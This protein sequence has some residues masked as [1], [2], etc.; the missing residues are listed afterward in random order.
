MDEIQ[1]K[2]Q[3]QR[4]LIKA[5]ILSSFT[6]QSYDEIEKAPSNISTGKIHKYVGIH[7]S[8]NGKRVY[9]YED[10]PDIKRIEGDFS[11]PSKKENEKHMEVTV[12][13]EGRS[14]KQYSTEE[15]ENTKSLLQK[16][17]NLDADKI[18]I[19]PSVS[20]SSLYL[21][22]RYN[23]RRFDIR[24]ADHTYKY[25]KEEDKILLNCLYK[26]K[27]YIIEAA[28]YNYSP[29]DIVNAVKS[30]NKSLNHFQSEKCQESIKE[31][32]QENYEKVGNDD[33]YDDYVLYPHNTAMDLAGLYITKHKI[34]DDEFNSKFHSIRSII[35]NELEKLDDDI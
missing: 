30:L 13:K 21:K 9:E 26:N 5:N 16:E 25:P 33:D 31:F 19:R 4:L 7:L 28:V 2:I 34:I 1:Y 29:D 17:L 12:D 15:I 27:K 20:T 23:N 22:F 18:K 35:E 24:L 32:T 11:Y 3:E 10:K 8:K 6:K 14:I